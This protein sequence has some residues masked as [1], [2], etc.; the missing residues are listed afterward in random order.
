MVLTLIITHVAAFVAGVFVYKNYL[1]YNKG[2]DIT[3]TV[4]DVIDEV[5]DKVKKK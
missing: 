5:K 2:K 3:D 1:S 4:E